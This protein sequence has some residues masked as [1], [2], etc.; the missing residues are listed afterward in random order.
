MRERRPREGEEGRPREGE[1]GRPREGEEGRPREGE[2]GRVCLLG[3][4]GEALLAFELLPRK[5]E[6]RLR[7]RSVEGQ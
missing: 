4:G 3:R 1:E 2:E 5:P 7:G 6:A